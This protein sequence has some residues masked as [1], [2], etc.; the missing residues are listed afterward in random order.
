[1]LKKKKLTVNAHYK[2]FDIY[3]CPKNK[4]NNNISD[5]KRHFLKINNNNNY[6]LLSKKISRFLKKKILFS[7]FLLK[8]TEFSFFPNPFL[9][10]PIGRR[11]DGRRYRTVSGWIGTHALVNEFTFYGFLHTEILIIW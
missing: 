3:I 6:R 10:H 7:S 8:V 9:S 11:R 4:F 2:L 1:M 5:K